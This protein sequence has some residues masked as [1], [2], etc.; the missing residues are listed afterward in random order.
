LFWESEGKVSKTKIKEKRR[1]CSR[2]VAPARRKLGQKGNSK[3]IRGPGSAK[4]V[5]V[6]K[7]LSK[8]T[9]GFSNKNKQSPNLARRKHTRDFQKG[10]FGAQNLPFTTRG[11]KNMLKKQFQRNGGGNKNGGGG[12]KMKAGQPTITLFGRKKKKK[13]KKKKKWAKKQHKKATNKTASKELDENK[14]P[15]AT[16]RV[17]SENIVRGGLSHG[18][19]LSPTS[20]NQHERT[21][22]KIRG[23]FKPNWV[24]QIC[25]EERKGEGG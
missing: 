5:G 3:K 7:K 24:E 10:L 6:P 22:P 15:Q 21:L 11:T 23:V 16:E 17:S 8:K 12:D 25:T 18:K 9:G 2:V 20:G 1:K 4:Q 14:I 19:V 13:K